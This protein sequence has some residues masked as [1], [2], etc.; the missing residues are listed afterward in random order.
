HPADRVPFALADVDVAVRPD[1]DGPR[2]EK[3]RLPIRAAVARFFLLAVTAKRADDAGVKV[4]HAD[5]LIAHVGDV[6]LA[7]AVQPDAVRLLALGFLAGAAVAA[8]TGLA[9]AGDRADRLR[10]RIDAADTGV[11]TVD[12]EQVALGVE[13]DAVRFVHRR[14]GRGAAVAGVAFVAVTRDR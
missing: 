11:Q 13:R 8:E 3:R 10:L 14:F 7:A 9:R 6:Q 2:S 5:A 12:D 4:Q 1:G